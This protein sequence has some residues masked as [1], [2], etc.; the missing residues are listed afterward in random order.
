MEWLLTRKQITTSLVNKGG[1][2]WGVINR[3]IPF[4]SSKHLKRSERDKT[5]GNQ[6]TEFGPLGSANRYSFARDIDNAFSWST[7]NII[8]YIVSFH[9]SNLFDALADELTLSFDIDQNTQDLTVWS[10]PPDVE[11]HGRSVYEVLNQLIDRKRGLFWF[12]EMSEDESKLDVVVETFND[13]EAELP[14]SERRLPAN[15]NI[16]S[17]MFSSAPNAGTVVNTT[18]TEK[19]YEQ[20]IVTGRRR[21]SVFTI[22]EDDGSLEA[23][24]TEDQETDYQNGAQDWLG[25]AAA[26][27]EKKQ[28]AND[29][30]R[31]SPELRDVYTAFQVPV[32]WDGTVKATDDQPA[33]VVFPVLELGDIKD[34]EEADQEGVRLLGRSGKSIDPG[35]QRY[36]LC[37]D[38]RSFRRA[39]NGKLFR[40]DVI[41][42]R[43]SFRITQWRIL[44]WVR[45]SCPRPS[46]RDHLVPA[47][48]APPAGFWRLPG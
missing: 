41:H 24:W 1:Q 34:P 42:K 4:N 22:Q 23:G 46:I 20:V 27:N 10:E 7:R 47:R 17:L 39:R 40:G 29:S 9:G 15:R 2:N 33:Q 16:V 25:Y 12:L 44:I 30:V 48:P 19:K 13:A 3:G 8:D 26:T 6:S 35:K 37:P 18:N 36:R 21:G 45:C 32:D 31:R 11:V 43:F 38:V 5:V 14:A 28:Q